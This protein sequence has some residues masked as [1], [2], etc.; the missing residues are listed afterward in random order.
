MRLGRWHQLLR[1]VQRRQV[2][3]GGSGATSPR[4]FPCLQ[5]AFSRRPPA[6]RRPLHPIG[7]GYKSEGG[8]LNA[9]ALTGSQAVLLGLGS[10]AVGAVIGAASSLLGVHLNARNEERRE[11]KR[12]VRQAAADKRS[13]LTD[14][15]AQVLALARVYVRIVKETQYLL[16]GDTAE[17]R[18]QRLQALLGEAN[19]S[20]QA[21]DLRLALDAETK[22]VR[23]AFQEVWHAYFDNQLA[24]THPAGTERTRRIGESVERLDKATTKL[25]ELAR[26][27]LSALDQ[28]RK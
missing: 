9:D 17:A 28:Q 21:A 27:Q 24:K 4:L 6:P 26:Q 2:A 23:D 1:L 16:E 19:K 12:S 18:D 7:Y 20:F 3:H 15:Y 8:L 11:T 22:D 14:D 25:E 10:A 5:S 13:R